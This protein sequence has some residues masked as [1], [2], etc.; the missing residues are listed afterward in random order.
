MAE[1]TAGGQD[2]QHPI[3]ATDE[4]RD[5]LTYRLSGDDAD[6]FTLNTSNG[7]LRTRSGV[8]YDYEDKDRY[9]VT[10]EA[11]DRRGA[12]AS[13]DVTIY[14]A[15]VDEPPEAP[16]RPRVEPASSTSLTVTWTEPANTGP[17]VD[18]Y[19]VQYRKSGSF[20]PWPHSGSGTSTTITDLDLNTRY[21]VQV[22]ASNDEG[23][24]GWSASGLGATSANQPPVFDEGGSATRSLAENTPP[25]RSIGNP[26]RATDPEGRAVTY[27][28]T[29]GDTD[30][31]T[32]DEDS[33]Q[34]RT[35]TGV[36]YNYE[37]R[38]RYSVTVEAQDEQG[39]RATIAVTI[40][41]TD[42]D[43]ERPQRPDRPSVT[44]STLTSLSVRWIEPSN[45]GPPITDY[46][47]QYREGS[48]GAFTAAA[49]DGTGTTTTIANLQSD[50]SYEI[51]VQATSDEGT[52]QWSPSGNGRTVANQAPTFTEGSST[53]RR[54]AE[55]TTGAHNI[56]NP[57]TATD[58]DGGTLTYRL[59]GTDRGLLHSRQSTSFRR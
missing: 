18:G 58:G 16:A 20:L 32:I 46:N 19:D 33:G 55:N 30:Q 42:D 36:E 21:E 39:G 37:A 38:N 35:Q 50:T 31:F 7:Q 53:T 51:Q 4:D 14:V 13:I 26:I 40:D 17:G 57:I 3:S 56:G 23:T 47:V 29:G 8:T 52:S 25:D 15:D 27:R 2:I 28:L 34:L 24:G 44:A 12:A 5:R 9:S 54:L 6:S 59:E 43:N 22:R 1:N 45:T 41:I 48:S 10:V 49:H 11:D